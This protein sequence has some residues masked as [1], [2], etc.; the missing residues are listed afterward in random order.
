M[1]APVIIGANLRANSRARVAYN[2][3]LAVAT[4]ATLTSDSNRKFHTELRRPDL[5]AHRCSDVVPA[6]HSYIT[7]CHVTRNVLSRSC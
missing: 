4:S 5:H 3:D 7:S 6:L 1:A 2:F